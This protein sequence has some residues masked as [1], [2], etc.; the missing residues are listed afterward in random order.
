MWNTRKPVLDYALKYIFRYQKTEKELIIQLR[1]KSYSEKE[2]STALEYLKEKNYINDLNYIND[3]I[4]YH[5]VKRWKPIVYAKSHLFEKWLNMHDV[6]QVISENMNDINKSINIQIKNEIEKYKQ[7][8]IN[9]LDIIHKLNR[10]WY[11]LTQIR[12]VLDN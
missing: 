9:P 2:I 5:L 8:Q 6:K 11:T 1:K 7:Q 10:K 3:Y 12:K 4:N